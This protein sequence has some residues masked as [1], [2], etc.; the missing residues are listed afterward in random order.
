[1]SWLGELTVETRCGDLFETEAEGIVVNTNVGA[2]LKAYALGEQLFDRCAPALLEEIDRAMLRQPGQELRVGH[3]ITVGAH[4]LEGIEKVVLVAWWG[5]HNR[6]TRN[7]CYKAVIAALRQAFEHEL[8][9]LAVPL[10]GTGSRQMQLSDLEGAITDV[11]HDLGDLR[12]ADAFSL[13]RLELVSVR[14]HDIDSLETHLR[15]Q[16]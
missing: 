6:F 2:R 10:M 14:Q 4:G 11:L 15:R 12:D 3:A 7:H 9:S 8:A 13:R 16:L 5:R 1:M